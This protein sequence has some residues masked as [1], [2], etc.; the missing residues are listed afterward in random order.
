MTT[1]NDNR[2]PSV[3]PASRGSELGIAA[4]ATPTLRGEEGVMEIP[5]HDTEK[6]TETKLDDGSDHTQ[7]DSAQD[8]DPDGDEEQYTSREGE[9]DVWTVDRDGP[10]DPQNPKK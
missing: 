4:S 8:P 1:H 7:T 5:A 10:D 6:G 9:S 2:Y 3:L